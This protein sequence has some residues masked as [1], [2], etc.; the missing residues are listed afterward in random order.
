MSR[1]T[2]SGLICYQEL[3]ICSNSLDYAPS[4]EPAL[5]RKPKVSEHGESIELPYDSV[6]KYTRITTEAYK[7]PH[8]HTSRQVTKGEHSKSRSKVR[9]LRWEHEQNV[10]YGLNREIEAER[11]RRNEGTEW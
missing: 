1:L 4:S 7:Q 8:K 5:L 3:F 6:Y 2:S 10:K 11:L 9:D